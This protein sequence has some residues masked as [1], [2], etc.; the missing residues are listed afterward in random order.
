MSIHQKS[1]RRSNNVAALIII[2][3]SALPVWAAA[4]YVGST[5]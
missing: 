4:Y 5:S 1:E 3:L 2:L